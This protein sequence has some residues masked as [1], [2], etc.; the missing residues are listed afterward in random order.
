VIDAT[1]LNGRPDLLFD[2]THPTLEGCRALAD[3]VSAALLR[4][5]AK[6]LASQ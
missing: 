3:L 6:L 4:N 1:P 2:H 5:S